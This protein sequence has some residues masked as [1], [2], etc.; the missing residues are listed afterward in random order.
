MMLLFMGLIWL[1]G[2]RTGLIALVVALLI[3]FVQGRRLPVGVVLAML[4][5]LPVLFY[6]VFGT[7]V[8]SNYLGRGG[9]TNVTSLNN[10][11]VAWSAALHLH[12]AFWD[13]WFGNG[14]SL[15]K[16]PVTADYRTDQ[17]LDSSWMSAL[18]QGGIV[19]VALL[20]LW[21]LAA[22]KACLRS[23]RSYRLLATALL[24]FVVSRSVLES[25]LIGATP[26]YLIFLIVSI[27]QGAPRLAAQAPLGAGMS[28]ASAVDSA[29]PALHQPGGSHR[30][31]VGLLT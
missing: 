20:T 22:L 5:A 29:E 23:P 12:K 11:T 4:A 3:L 1:T 10:R 18:V 19:G 31:D 2:S 28:A 24:G 26:I 25:G 16:I 15:V 7:S 17:I 30:R 21:I 8:V 14:L 27:R 6:L 9:S 13:T